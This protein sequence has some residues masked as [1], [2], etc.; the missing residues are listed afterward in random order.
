MKPFFV[1]TAMQTDIPERGGHMLGGAQRSPEIRLVDVAEADILAAE[2]VEY[3]QIVPA[4]M[5]H[6]YHQWIFAKTL[7][8]FAEIVA[9]VINVLE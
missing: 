9:I 3:F 5:A 1:I 8:K 2:V 6:F 4:G 7:D